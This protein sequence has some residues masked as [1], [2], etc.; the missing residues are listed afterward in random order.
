MGDLVYCPNPSCGNAM[1][2]NDQTTSETRQKFSHRRTQSKEA[3]QSSSPTNSTGMLS[4]SAPSRSMSPVTPPPIS[5][6]IQEAFTKRV[7][8]THC[9]HR[10]CRLCKKEWHEGLTCQENEAK[11][12]DVQEEQ[13]KQ[14]MEE[15]GASNVK[16]CPKCNITILKNRGCNSMKCANCQQ[17]FCWFCGEMFNAEDEKKHFRNCTRWSFWGINISLY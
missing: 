4:T 10:F 9:R 14:W 7:V 17:C 2:V 15:T 5:P 11:Q 3:E 8:C 16:N 1:I 12:K 6:K 13:F